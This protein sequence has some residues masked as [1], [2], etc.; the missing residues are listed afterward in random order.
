MAE[1][2]WFGHGCF[3]VRGREATIVLDPVGKSTG[4]ALPRQK[5]DI[6]TISGHSLKD[7]RAIM[8]CHYLHRDPTLA[9]SAIRKLEMGNKTAS[10]TPN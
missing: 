5:A 7:T 3:R 6:V 4:Y 10:K 1:I 9:A 8:D 2:K